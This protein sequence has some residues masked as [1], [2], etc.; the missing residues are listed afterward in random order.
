MDS[1]APADA[2]PP[3]I[4][5]GSGDREFESLAEGETILI[6]QGPQ[7][8]YHFLGSVRATN[9][10]A[11]DP[12]DLGSPQNPTTSFEVFV[13]TSRVDAMASTYKQGL[14]ISENGAEMIGR[15]VIL[16]IQVDDELDGMQVRFV[17][18]IDD[19]DGVSISDERI[20][21]AKPHPNNR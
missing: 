4:E 8:G 7:N 18:R 12:K 16:D 11:G 6:V 17:V 10:N 1:L 15:N 14:K 21:L 9:I 3:T 13:G 20:L 19:V 2:G 5:I